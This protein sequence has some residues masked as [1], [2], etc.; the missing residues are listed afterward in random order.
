MS[1]GMAWALAKW[2][3]LALFIF[4]LTVFLFVDTFRRVMFTGR[5]Q[6]V[7]AFFSNSMVIILTLFI[8]YIIFSIVLYL[9]FAV[10][11]PIARIL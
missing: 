10:F 6:G 8:Y 9:F 2:V 11:I 7:G 3:F 5:S 1:V 4:G